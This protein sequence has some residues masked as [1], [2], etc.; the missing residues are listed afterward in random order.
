MCCVF[1]CLLKYA[2]HHL[3][4]YYDYIARLMCTYIKYDTIK[5]R[6]TFDEEKQIST[7][8]AITI[9]MLFSIR[10]LKIEFTK[11][12]HS[13]QRYFYYLHNLFDILKKEHLKS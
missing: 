8:F 1:N 11:I 4:Y 6:C 5:S 12:K 9:F 3:F 10:E 2:V 13:F 7:P